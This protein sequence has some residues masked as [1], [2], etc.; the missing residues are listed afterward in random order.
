[1]SLP[2]GG[3]PVQNTSYFFMVDTASGFGEKP[4]PNFY[5]LATIS[6]Q[7][8]SPPPDVLINNPTGSNTTDA[9]GTITLQSTTTT[10]LIRQ[11]NSTVTHLW[12]AGEQITVVSTPYNLSLEYQGSFFSALVVPT[13]PTILF[14]YLVFSIQE[15]LDAVNNAFEQA[16]T[17][18]KAAF[19]GFPGS[20]PPYVYYNPVQRLFGIV[21]E[22]GC[23]QNNNPAGGII[24]LGFVLYRFF[25]NFIVFG[26]LL[27]TP[28]F[29]AAGFAIDIASLGASAAFPSGNLFT[30]AIG[31]DPYNNVAAYEAL[32]QLE[33]SSSLCQWNHIEKLLIVSGSLPVQY[34]YLATAPSIGGTNIQSSSNFQAILVDF[35][36]SEIGIDRCEAIYNADPYRLIDLRGNSPL[37]SLDLQILYQDRELRN[38]PLLISP[39]DYAEVKLLFRKKFLAV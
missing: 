8:V 23:W 21:A 4:V 2:A 37:R 29:P 5:N 35:I 1:M 17:A 11:T 39:G 32:N 36:V 34:E 13:P 15:Y 16:F 22:Y 38:Y 24:Y 20:H 12:P 6:P 3:N 30:V 14:N 31:A 33:Q 18:L 10:Q 25:Q 9:S 27:N 19:P 28:G 26:Q 7:P